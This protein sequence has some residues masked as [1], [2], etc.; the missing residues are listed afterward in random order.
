MSF[1]W[2]IIESIVDQAINLPPEERETYIRKNCGD[3]EQLYMEVKNMLDSIQHSEGWMDEPDLVKD[4]FLTDIENEKSD[5][6]D[7]SAVGAVVDKYKLVDI[8]GRGGMGTVYLAER[9][10]DSYKNR[11]AIKILRRGLDSEDM[12]TRFRIEQQVLAQLNH[13]NITHI[14]DAGISED[15]RPY[16]V[17]EFVEGLPITEYC[18]INNLSTEERLELFLQICGA[19][20]FAHQKL[21][22]HRDLKPANILVTK[23][24]IVK[25]LD[26]GIAKI[27]SD[28]FLGEKSP[29]ITSHHEPI[30]TITYASP[31]QIAGQPI[32]TASDIYTLSI[33]LYQLLT[34]DHPYNASGIEPHEIR[35]ELETTSIKSPRA[36]IQNSENPAVPI[37]QLRDEIDDII[38]KGLHYEPELRYSSIEEFSRDIRN[39][40]SNRPVSAKKP[41]RSYRFKKFIQR[42]R[43]LVTLGTAASIL[44]IFS[45]TATL[46][47]ANQ[48]RIEAERALAASERVV[49]V[50][51]FLI[52]MITAGNPWANPEQPQTA[53]D[54]IDQGAFAAENEL[55]DSP[56]LA[57]ELFGVIGASYQ[58]MREDALAEEYLTKAMELIDQGVI[59]D[60]LVEADI[61]AKY[62]GS[63]LRAGQPDEAETVS[64]DALKKIRN[65]DGRDITLMESELL[66]MLANAYSLMGDTPKAIENTRLSVDLT[67]NRPEEFILQCIDYLTALKNLEEWGGNYEEGLQAAE[68]AYDL[69]QE[70]QSS[71]S[72]QMRLAVFGTYGNALSYNAQTSVAIPLLEENAELAGRRYGFDSYRYARALYDLSTAY[73]FAGRTVDALLTAE[74][75][76]EI[77]AEN[78]MGN[79]MNSYWLYRAFRIAIDLHQPNYAQDIYDR[80]F[81]TLPE[82]MTTHYVDGFQ[83]EFLKLNMLQSPDSPTLREEIYQLYDSFMERRSAHTATAA[84]AAAEQAIR[85]NNPD[86]AEMYV[87]EYESAETPSSKSDIRPAQSLMIKS[88]IS[89]LQDDIN[90]AKVYAEE[91]LRL[92]RQIGHK[93]SPYVAEANL[94][95]GKIHCSNDDDEE[96][97]QYFEKSGTYWE[98]IKKLHPELDEDVIYTNRCLR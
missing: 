81:H 38:L 41:S 98:S 52:S 6:L 56:D 17:M 39:Y 46:W 8:I 88:N 77:Q 3:S 62:S 1:D 37:Q 31:E 28:D 92:L 34:G 73:E 78:Q 64:N 16:Y 95:L 90:Q 23:S 33:V 12:L 66:Y 2:N 84:L 85:N 26:F 15:G 94:L 69:A 65:L 57:A 5:F 97:I 7:E 45:F 49:A 40:L 30:Y 36:V 61:K 42:N 27:L 22:I 58:G 51:D 24:G 13:P 96:A 9:D 47:Q 25:L 76:L 35:T 21:V 80:F 48:T 68:R 44:L 43:N 55:S 82:Q 50:K 54:L 89:L 29:D 60:P 83:L 20:T 87:S 70:F 91:S 74:Q 18:E 14:L 75:V 4:Q 63:M 59:L 93:E 53:R 71:I 11:V 10:D 19:L 79:P 72:D 86:T 32:G 67:C